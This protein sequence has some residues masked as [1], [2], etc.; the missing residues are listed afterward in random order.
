MEVVYGTGVLLSI[1]GDLRKFSGRR[2]TIPI[3]GSFL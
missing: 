3:T 1:F 2:R